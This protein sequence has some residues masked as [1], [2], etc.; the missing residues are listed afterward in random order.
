VIKLDPAD[1][2]TIALGEEISVVEL[3]ER[4]TTLMKGI[5]GNATP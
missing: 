3:A 2:D 5:E 1:K 4:L